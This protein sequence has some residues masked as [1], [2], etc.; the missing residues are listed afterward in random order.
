[1]ATVTIHGTMKPGTAFDPGL[2]AEHYWRLHAQSP[3]EWET[4]VAYR[5]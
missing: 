5:G 3:G 2:I 4:E 1:M